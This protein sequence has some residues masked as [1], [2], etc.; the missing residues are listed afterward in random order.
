M[1]ENRAGLI[2]SLAKRTTTQGSG[3]ILTD[4]ALH[5]VVVD[6][7]L[8]RQLV[9]DIGFGKG[10]GLTHEPCQSLPQRVDPSLYMGRFAALLAHALV[11]F[12]GEDVLIRF[13]EVAV[14][15]TLLVRIRYPLPQLSTTLLA[16]ISNEVGYDLACATAQSE[17]HPPLVAF[18]ED[19]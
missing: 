15:A 7:Q 9:E 13:P 4:G 5:I 14:G 6:E 3:Y 16:A 12:T 1:Y 11:G 17:P 8:Q 10:Q 18:L 19:K 2:D